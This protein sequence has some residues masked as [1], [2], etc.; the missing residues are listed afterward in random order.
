MK[1]TF[2]PKAKMKLNENL[3][4]GLLNYKQS[5]S[6]TNTMKYIKNIFLSVAFILQFLFAAGQNSQVAD[7]LLKVYETKKEEM[8]NIEKANMLSKIGSYYSNEQV[9]SKSIILKKEALELYRSENELT[10]EIATLEQIGVLYSN[11][12]NYNSALSYFLEGLKLAEKKKDQKMI[13]AINLNIGITYIEAENY[14]K[15]LEYLHKCQAYYEKDKNKNAGPLLVVYTDLGAIHQSINQLDS[16]QIYFHKALSICKSTNNDGLGGVLI[17]LGDLYTKLK[18]YAE[19]LEY[20][21]QGLSYFDQKKDL[22]GYWHSKYSIAHLAYCQQNYPEAIAQY[23]KVIDAF[24]KTD[25]LSYLSDSY[26]DLSKIYREIGQSD[27]ALDYYIKYTEINEKIASGEVLTQ[28]AQLEMQYD[29][30]KLEQKTKLDI[31]LINKQKQLISYRWYFISGIL[32]IIILII[33]SILHR[34]K[35]RK[36]LIEVK[37]LN[38]EL[39]Q[40]NLEEEIKYSKKELESFA[41][42]IVHNNEFL[43]TIKKALH[44]MKDSKDGDVSQKIRELSFQIT[45]SLRRNKDI[46]KLQERIDLVHSSFMKKLS[47][48]FPQL[49]EKEKRL[50]VMLK[51]DLSSKEIA[52]LNN[53]SENAVM[54]ARYRMRKK[55]NM[56][57]EE[58]LVDFLQKIR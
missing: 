32:I 20:Y 49:T 42:H 17:N 11:I 4:N 3:K 25:D 30:E 29:L 50:C 27:K 6:T 16:A 19:A 38:A 54:M 47:E 7:S 21:N 23:Q 9:Y 15:G 28:M 52:V 35:N 18:K 36:K 39:E 40:K 13:H 37:L 44:E 1:T 26:L 45:Q 56:N 43:L 10:K 5:K 57:S 46:E 41:L 12:C 22:R 31:E 58:N 14:D 53:I 2:N 55:M 8:S 48:Q 24:I 33:I 34:F 51:L